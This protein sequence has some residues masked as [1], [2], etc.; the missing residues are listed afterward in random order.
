MVMTWSKYLLARAVSGEHAHG[1]YAVPC[2]SLLLAPFSA[3]QPSLDISLEGETLERA[4][5]AV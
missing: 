5:L 2:F 4:D 3:W 1:W